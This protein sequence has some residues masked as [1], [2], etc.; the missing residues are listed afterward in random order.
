[1][2]KATE[3]GLKATYSHHTNNNNYNHNNNMTAS[4][5]SSEPYL[6]RHRDSDMSSTMKNE[7][8]SCVAEEYAK[9][10]GM[11]EF[12]LSGKLSL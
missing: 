6:G 4:R 9:D 12:L 3:M 7:Q 1:M 2:G 10:L 5:I 8:I 11:L